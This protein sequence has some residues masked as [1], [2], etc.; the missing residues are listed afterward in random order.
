V[1]GVPPTT[2]VSRLKALGVASGGRR[3]AG[4]S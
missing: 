1:L 3:A 4:A 2:L